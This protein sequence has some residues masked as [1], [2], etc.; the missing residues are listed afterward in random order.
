MWP[1]G[2]SKFPTP[3]Y[4]SSPRTAGGG[5]YPIVRFETDLPRIE[6]ANN[7]GGLS[8]NH[9]TGAGCTNPPPGAFYPWYH[10]LRLPSSGACAWGLTNNMPHQLK[11]FGGEKAAWGPL[12]RTNYGFDK[13]FHNFARSITNPCP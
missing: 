10:L 3:N 7:G 12:E 13:R 8:C 6:E 2:S 1:N 11:N 4:L 9:H 5:T